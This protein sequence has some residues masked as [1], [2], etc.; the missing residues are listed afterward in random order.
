MGKNYMKYIK[1]FIGIVI[2][3]SVF[4]AL[5]IFKPGV[6]NISKDKTRDASAIF[7]TDLENIDKYLGY[8]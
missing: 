2:L 3:F 7:Y 1:L 4:S 5:V 8:K 6:K